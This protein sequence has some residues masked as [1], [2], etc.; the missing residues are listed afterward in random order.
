MA[1]KYP[2]PNKR[3]YDIIRRRFLDPINYL[4]IKETYSTLYL[5]DKRSGKIQ[6][7]TKRN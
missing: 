7:I 6:I 3:Q 1:K 5:W 2:R 4:V